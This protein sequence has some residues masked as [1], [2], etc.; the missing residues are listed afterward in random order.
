MKLFVAK[1]I[2]K[3]LNEP[4]DARWSSSENLFTLINK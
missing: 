1:N 4:E 2:G 3:T